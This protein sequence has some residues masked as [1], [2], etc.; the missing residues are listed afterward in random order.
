[1]GNLR[2]WIVLNEISA[3]GFQLPSPKKWVL[4]EIL[5][6]IFEVKIRPT[7]VNIDNCEKNGFKW[8]FGNWFFSCEI[9]AERSVRKKLGNWISVVL[10]CP[11]LVVLSLGFRKVSEAY[12]FPWK[13]ISNLKEG[14]RR[15]VFMTRFSVGF[16]YCS[17]P[18]NI[19]IQKTHIEWYLA[20]R[21]PCR[22]C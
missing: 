5:K 10:S 11:S 2:S 22:K 6:H 18:R 14:M 16:I 4:P 15:N 3:K 1:M 7:G 9:S 21:N 19:S 20:F 8:N 13:G 17:S 12:S